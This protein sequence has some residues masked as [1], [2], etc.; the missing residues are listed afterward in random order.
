MDRT[1]ALTLAGKVEATWFNRLPPAQLNVWIEALCDLDEGAA[2]TAYARLRGRESNMTVA[3][4]C[5][6][7]RSIRTTDGGTERRPPCGACDDSGWI[8]AEPY[9]DTA[10]VMA[11]GKHPTYTQVKPCVCREGRARENSAVWTEHHP[12]PSDHRNAA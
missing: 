3:R 2:G 11:N 7:V 10:S 9:V 12:H 1:A 8:E 6:E 4:F 5:A